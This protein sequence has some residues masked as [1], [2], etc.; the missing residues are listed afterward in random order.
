MANKRKSSSSIDR[1]LS[2]SD[3]QKEAEY[4]KIDREF[5]PALGKPLTPDERKLWR[6]TKRRIGRPVVGQGSKMVPV[7]IER[8]L[9]QRVDKFARQHK[10][11]RSQMVAQGLELVMRRAS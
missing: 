1:F 9:L 6:R 10:L 2:L 4:R 5:D 11:K 7:T 3:A 8:G